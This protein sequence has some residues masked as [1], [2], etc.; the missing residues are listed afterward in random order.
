MFLYKI[1]NKR[2]VVALRVLRILFYLLL[3]FFASQ[4][5]EVIL[6]DIRTVAS[7]VWSIL[8]FSFFWIMMIC[9]MIMLTPHVLKKMWRMWRDRR[10]RRVNEEPPFIEGQK[11]DGI[12]F[13]NHKE[14]HIIPA[15]E[16][17]FVDTIK[18]LKEDEKKR[19]M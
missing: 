10:M 13:G 3:L 15:G 17:H 11:D 2:L 19:S 9:E 16:Y 1:Q 6:G 7:V 4:I 18:G 8:W 14:I 5:R 12:D